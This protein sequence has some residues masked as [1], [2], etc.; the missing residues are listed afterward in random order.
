MDRVKAM[1]E[2]RAWLERER[3]R[4]AS[5]ATSILFLVLVVKCHHVASEKTVSIFVSLFSSLKHAI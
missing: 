4:D 3:E 2:M 5:T 1:A